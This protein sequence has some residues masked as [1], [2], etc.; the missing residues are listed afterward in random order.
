MFDGLEGQAIIT[1]DPYGE[2]EKYNKIK[3]ELTNFIKQFEILQ[4][5]LGEI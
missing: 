5:K 3:K 1:K 4:N 2:R